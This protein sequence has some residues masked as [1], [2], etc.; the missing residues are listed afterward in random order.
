MAKIIAGWLTGGILGIILSFLNYCNMDIV[1]LP[2]SPILFAASV[3]GALI[4]VFGN[5]V[6]SRNTNSLIGVLSG[7]F[8]FSV[9]DTGFSYPII[10]MG[11]ITG[12][13]VSYIVG[14]IP[15]P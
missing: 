7:C 9:I 2:Y 15:E 5:L 13:T 4:G 11:F 8:T 1:Q 10:L 14:Q 12:L 6:K 3:T